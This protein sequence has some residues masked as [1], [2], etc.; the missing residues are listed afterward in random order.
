VTGKI[1]DDPG[2]LA[3]MQRDWK[4]FGPPLDAVS[5]AAPS[6][7]IQYGLG[8]MRFEMPAWSTPLGKVPAVV[9]HTGSTGSWAFYCPALELL[10]V[11]T[12]DQGTAGPIP[13]RFV[14]K[15]L[16]EIAHGM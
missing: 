11:G 12:V 14:P 1:F 5:L 16:Q 6:W 13:F 7:P 4:R 3:L 2:T 10:F 8:M 9:G 15:L